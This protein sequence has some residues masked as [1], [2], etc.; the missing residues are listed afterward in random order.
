[1]DPISDMLISVKNAGLAGKPLAT[2]PY[3]NMKFEIANVLLK[4]GY[5]KSFSIKGKKVNKRIEI[6]IAYSKDKA[7][8]I[9][10]VKRISKPARRI[11]A[12]F[13]QI[14]RG[15]PGISVLSTPRGIMTDEEAKKALVGGELLFKI[16]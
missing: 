15:S 8:K 9:E 1:M 7:P 5:I 6:E 12:G 16:W 11:Y 2:V 14:P 3:S 13:R 10:D 4:S